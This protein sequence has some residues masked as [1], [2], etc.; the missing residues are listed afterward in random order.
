M[1][2][3]FRTRLTWDIIFTSQGP[4]CFPKRMSSKIPIREYLS[5]GEAYASYRPLAEVTRN[6]GVEMIDSAIRYCRMNG[7]KGL[8]IDITGLTGF[9]PPSTTDRFFFIKKWV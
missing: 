4:N 1:T 7:I 6:E 2:A 9:A 8:L 5:L 3:F